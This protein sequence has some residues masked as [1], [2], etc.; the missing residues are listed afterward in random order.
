ML[1]WRS[2]EKGCQLGS[3]ATCQFLVLPFVCAREK[4]KMLSRAEWEWSGCGSRHALSAPDIAPVL[5]SNLYY[6]FLATLSALHR[7]KAADSDQD[8][9]YKSVDCEH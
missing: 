6:C 3:F 1:S 2:K 7:K 9:R 5:Y 8:T 4:Q